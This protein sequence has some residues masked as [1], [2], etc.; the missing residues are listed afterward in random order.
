M[1]FPFDIHDEECDEEKDNHTNGNLENQVC[2]C[3]G[4]MTFFLNDIDDGIDLIVAQLRG[5]SQVSFL[6]K[7][8]ITVGTL[9]VAVIGEVLCQEEE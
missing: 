4:L 2:T 9:C 1:F 5:E 3:Q 8:H 6:G 7:L